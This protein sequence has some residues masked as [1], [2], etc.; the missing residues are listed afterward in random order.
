MAALIRLM[1]IAGMGEARLLICLE[2]FWTRMSRVGKDM[3]EEG[4]NMVVEAVAEVAEAVVRLG[5]IGLR[6]G[7]VVEVQGVEVR[8]TPFNLPR[9]FF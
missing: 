3:G 4:I 6:M 1:G 7:P 2:R 9:T 8:I 5:L